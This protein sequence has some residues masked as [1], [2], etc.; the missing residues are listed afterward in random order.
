MKKHYKAYASGWDGAKELRVKLMD[1][2]TP[3][4]VEKI[5]TEYLSTVY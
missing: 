3:E 5:V 2:A 1:S 4:E